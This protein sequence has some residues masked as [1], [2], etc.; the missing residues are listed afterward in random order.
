MKGMEELISVLRTKRE[1]ELARD[2]TEAMFSNESFFFRDIKPFD[3]LRNVVLPELLKNRAT[4]KSF[5]IWC[6]AFSSGQES[7]I[8]AKVLKEEATKGVVLGRIADLIPKEGVLFL[9][10]A[11]TVSG[12]SNRFKP[13]AVQRGVYRLATDGPAAASSTVTRGFCTSAN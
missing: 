11:E 2:V 5:R 4:K 6:A 1:E 10:G 8:L 7:Y 9:G 12:I 3:L 13:M